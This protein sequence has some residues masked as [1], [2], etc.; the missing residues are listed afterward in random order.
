MLLLFQ[1][2]AH[3]VLLGELLHFSPWLVAASTLPHPMPY[4][5]LLLECPVLQHAHCTPF[6]KKIKKKNIYAVYIQ[7]K[8]I[9]YNMIYYICI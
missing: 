4:G 6:V 7:Y 5:T 3:S 2:F 8:H 1:R 9:V